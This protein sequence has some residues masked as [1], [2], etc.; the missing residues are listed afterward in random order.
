MLFFVKNAESQANVM[1]YRSH[2]D[3][4]QVSLLFG[5]KQQPFTSSLILLCDIAEQFL[6]LVLNN[7]YPITMILVTPKEGTYNEKQKNTR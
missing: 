2:L 7:N 5:I 4:L 3:E 6:I 1:R